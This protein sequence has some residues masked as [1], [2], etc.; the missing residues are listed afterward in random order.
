MIRSNVDIKGIKMNDVEILLSQFADD[1]SILLDGSEKSFKETILT[2]DQFSRYSGLKMNADKT[3]VIWIGRNKNCDIRYMRDRNFIWDPGAFKILGI[4]FST[5]IDEIV[6]LNYRDK[7]EKL[8]KNLGQWRKR[9][10]T[11]LGRITVIKSLIISTITYLFINLPDP[12]SA[13]LEE[14]AKEL[15]VFL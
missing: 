9:Q 8:K 1:T 6:D 4:Q 13:F 7:I 2:L 15:N 14:L 10:L 3:N 5:E 11:V 12:S